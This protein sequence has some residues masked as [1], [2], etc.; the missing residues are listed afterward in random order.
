MEVED[1]FYDPEESPV[2][3]KRQTAKTGKMEVEDESSDQDEVMKKRK[4]PSTSMFDEFGFPLPSPA[5]SSSPPSSPLLSA[6][7]TPPSS[8]SSDASSS[9]G[10]PPSQSSSFDPNFTT[11]HSSRSSSSPPSSSSD[12]RPSSDPPSPPSRSASFASNFT[13]PQS[14]RSSSS[15]PSSSEASS[16]SGPPSPSSCPPYSPSTSPSSSAGS[17]TGSP[18]SPPPPYTGIDLSAWTLRSWFPPRCQYLRPTDGQDLPAEFGPWITLSDTVRETTW[19]NMRTLFK[20][21]AQWSTPDDAPD[22]AMEVED[23]QQLEDCIKAVLYVL[24]LF[25]YTIL[26]RM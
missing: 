11:P 14:S 5:F 19:Q 17:T 13:T 26:A 12:S 8:S 2:K 20:H 15:S 22:A 21:Q 16:S 24:L 1:E 6:H 4:N 25:S 9:S 18:S 3:K 7:F 10:S 23:R